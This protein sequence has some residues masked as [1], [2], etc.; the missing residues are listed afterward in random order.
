MQPLSRS[1]QGN[2]YTIKWMFGLPEAVDS[3]H[4]LHLDQGSVI[5]VIRKYRDFLIIASDCRRIVLANEVADR[6]QV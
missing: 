3:L 4:A 1:T 5:R 6:I 2:T